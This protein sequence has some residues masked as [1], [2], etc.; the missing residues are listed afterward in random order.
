MKQIYDL[1]KQYCLNTQENFIRKE[2]ISVDLQ[3]RESEVSHVL[4]KLNLEGFVNQPLQRPPHDSNRD[5]TNIGFGPGDSSWQG[6]VY[7]LRKDDEC[8]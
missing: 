4:H 7:Y 1:V 6:D 5:Y 3:L 2:Q 8:L